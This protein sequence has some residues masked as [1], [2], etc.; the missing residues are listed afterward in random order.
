MASNGKRRHP[1][2]GAPSE[3]EPPPP[4]KRPRARRR[5]PLRDGFIE[6]DEV[7]R[8]PE[9]PGGSLVDMAWDEEAQA[10]VPPAPAQAPVS[11]AQQAEKDEPSFGTL[12]RRVGSALLVRLARKLDPDG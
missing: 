5:K 1:L 8:A 2:I 7:L 4:L 12:L 6:V 11:V 10:P 3:D 9:P